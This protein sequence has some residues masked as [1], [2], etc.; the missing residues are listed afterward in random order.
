M[1]ERTVAVLAGGLSHEREVSLRSGT[2]AGGRTA[3]RRDVRAGV[4][5]RRRADRAVADGAARTPS[6][7]PCTG[8]RGRTARS[9]PCWSC[10]A[11]R[12]SARRR[13]PAAA[14]GTSR[15]RRPSSPAPG[16]T[17]RT[18]SPS[19]TRR[20]AS[21]APAAVLDAMVERLGLPLMLKP[22]QGGSALGAQVVTDAGGPSRR[23]GELPGLRR[24]RAGGAVR[25]RHRGR[26]VRRGRRGGAARAP[27]R[28]GRGEGRRSTTT[29]P[30]TRPGAT[31]F[32][33]PARL[34]DAVL[35]TL[36]ETALAA[37]RL[38][39]LRDVSRMDAVVDAARA[40]ADPRGQRLPGPDRHLTAPDGRRGGRAPTW[41]C[42]SPRSWSGR[43]PAADGAAMATPLWNTRC[44]RGSVSRGT[45][46]VPRGTSAVKSAVERPLRGTV[47][48]Q[49]NR[50][51]S[52]GQVDA[53][54]G[55]WRGRYRLY[56]APTSTPRGAALGAAQPAG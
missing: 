7:S 6:S 23:D 51:D 41:A 25:R 9:R 52:G 11:C 45:L 46:A 15:P 43:S 36:Q 28:R 5:R 40:G 38:L 37:H 22:D 50:R 34:D 54:R 56:R 55:R 24:H 8:A 3:R 17:P 26:G 10:S 49:Q 31:T 33:C 29:P 47:R 42:S 14:P 21:W 12:S 44:S 27:A 19:R 30:A 13:R 35:T 16:S 2:A 20:S 32:H 53:P 18:G 48:E 39:G 4:G 1:T